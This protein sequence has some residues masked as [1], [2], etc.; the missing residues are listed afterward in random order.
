MSLRPLDLETRVHRTFLACLV[1]ATLA[2][3]PTRAEL[4]LPERTIVVRNFAR[5][6]QD[7]LDTLKVNL[8]DMKVEIEEF[9]GADVVLKVGVTAEVGDEDQAE[10][11]LRRHC[12][13]L[14]RRAFEGMRLSQASRFEFST[15]SEKESEGD[16]NDIVVRLKSALASMRGEDEIEEESESAS[17]GESEPSPVAEGD[18]ATSKALPP[19]SANA[20]AA[21]EKNGYLASLR[22]AAEQRYRD[23]I[24]RAK[25]DGPQPQP[26]ESGPAAKPTTPKADQP[27]QLAAAA[28]S[29][30]ALSPSTTERMARYPAVPRPKPVGAD[31]QR[32]VQAA[33]QQKNWKARREA[34][35][36]KQAARRKLVSRISK[37]SNVS[38]ETRK[39]I[40][41]YERGRSSSDTVQG[42]YAQIFQDRRRSSVHTEE[43]I[44]VGSPMVG[45]TPDPV[46]P[47]SVPAL[48]LA[49][50]PGPPAPVARPPRQAPAKPS[51]AQTADALLGSKIEALFDSVEASEKGGRPGLSMVA[52][53]APATPSAREETR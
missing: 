19:P 26:Q 25:G 29:Q 1:A 40:Q 8:P 7:L 5:K 17:E 22:N 28:P 31:A 23:L 3:P 16:E 41:A 46:E 37:A 48:A 20:E 6:R 49:A 15:D 42:I 43:T 18:E 11:T 34:L 36:A 13:R 50:R 24:A 47:A 52:S 9:R 30:G 12:D 35:R 53:S 21:F 27:P 45:D 39:A 4:N 2:A 44:Q 51:V 14:I 33:Q 32:R 38:P 10:R